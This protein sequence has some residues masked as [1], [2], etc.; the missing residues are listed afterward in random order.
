MGK[1]FGT[2]ILSWRWGEK[3]KTNPLELA[4]AGQS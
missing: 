3:A 1:L 2:S 4:V